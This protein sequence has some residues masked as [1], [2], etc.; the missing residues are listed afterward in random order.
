MT[1]GA[2]LDLGFV[3]ERLPCRVRGGAGAPDR[4]ATLFGA[5]LRVLTCGAVLLLTS[6]V[7]ASPS[8]AGPYRALFRALE[9]LVGLFLVDAVW[10]FANLWHSPC[11][12]GGGGSE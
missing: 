8:R 2:F 9:L 7:H 3:I 11:L 5:V 12:L 4:D 6:V 1:P 10:Q